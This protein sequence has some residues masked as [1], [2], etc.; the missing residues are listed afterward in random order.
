MA[1]GS[2]HSSRARSWAND[3]SRRRRK[4]SEEEHQLWSEVARSTSPLHT[5]KATYPIEDTGKPGKPV[6]EPA[7]T[8]DDTIDDKG[9]C[10]Q[11][12]RPTGRGDEP[13]T[14]MVLSGKPGVETLQMDRRAYERLNRG[15]MA[16]Q[17]RLDLHGMTLNDAHSTLRGFILRAHSEGLR[18]VLVITGKGKAGGSDAIIPERHGVLRHQVPH[19]LRL[20]PLS[21]LILQVSPAHRK[22]GGE[23]AYYVYLR[24]GRARA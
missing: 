9:R 17:S 1:G 5:R 3:V 6:A 23:G 16:P 20:P 14:R 12:L 11:S 7:P 22:H 13:R 15:K 8:F 10:A 19:W 2:S 4:L 21:G 24:R 18:L